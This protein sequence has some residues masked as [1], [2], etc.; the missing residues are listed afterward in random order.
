MTAATAAGVLLRFC[1][2]GGCAAA[3]ALRC[4]PIGESRLG[5]SRRKV[6]QELVN[7]PAEQGDESF[8]VGV[9]EGGPAG[10]RENGGL[11]VGTMQVTTLE[12]RRE[13]RGDGWVSGP[14][15]ASWR[16]S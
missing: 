11:A 3:S 6:K 8:V 5:Q 1:F 7:I 9:A 12:R 4:A 16:R 14:G 15:R 10:V 13:S 2:L